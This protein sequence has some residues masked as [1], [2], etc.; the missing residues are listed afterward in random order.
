LITAHREF[1][2][3]IRK[4]GSLMIAVAAGTVTAQ[5]DLLPD[6]IVDKDRLFD[7]FVQGNELRLSNGTANIGPGK[8]HIYGGQDNGDGTQQVIQRIFRTDGTHY[9]RVGGNFV[10]HPQHNHIHVE[11]WAS[12]RLREILPGDGV[13][14]IVAEGAKTS[15]C[16]I[17]LGIYDTTLPNYNPSGEFFSCGSRTQGLSVGW[18]DVY[19][20][21]LEG[22]SIDIT[23]VPAGQYW[24]ESVVDPDNDFLEANEDN[25][26]SR[27]KVTLGGGGGSIDPDVYE[28]NNS[29][30]ETTAR[31]VGG[32]NS[33]NLGPVGPETRIEG[34]T[35]HTSTDDD[36]FRF[37]MPATGGS[38]DFVRIEFPH[39]AGDVD[40]RLLSDS[41]STLE[42]SQGTSNSEQISLQG[43][44]A[45]WYVVEIYGW[46]GATSPS[47]DLIIN[48]SSNGAPI[49]DL[50]NPPAGDTRRQ[51][52]NETYTLNWTA[53]DPE[54]NPTWVTIF[55]NTSPSF[56]GNEI[57]LPTSL[58]TPGAQGMY[59]VNSA[60]L[61]PDESYWFYA[62]VTD[63][64]SV[65]G[66]WSDGTVTFYDYCDGDIANDFGSIGP[67]GQV[68]FGDFLALLGLVGPCQ[69]GTPG[70]IGD[71]ADDF[72]TLGGDGQVSFGDF[73]A[74][75]GLVG[76]C[77]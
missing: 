8:F 25:N 73:L 59:V 34:L 19:S 48:P 17:D 69:G 52:G 13:G 22:Q 18:V 61:L 27:I 47:V 42:T 54:N 16:I 26:S 46:N 53:S 72:G 30:A 68:S 24:L 45:G 39:S 9:D 75:L 29:L 20:S 41:G 63:G 35:L 37:Y 33:P 12:Y 6:I 21:G 50:I 56:N 36:Y 57:L 43:R 4:L 7:H 32:I 14:P 55:A 15:F 77:E 74:Q 64:G 49:V 60:E 3:H 31:P 71:I 51:H 67:D 11:A 28:P 40:M 44:A 23:G 62:Q 10:Y 65:R 2:V 5:T 76:P 70:C 1:V 66:A 38:G 58:N